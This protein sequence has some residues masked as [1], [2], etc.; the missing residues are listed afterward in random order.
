MN[1]HWWCR[2]PDTPVRCLYIH[3]GINLPCQKGEAPSKNTRWIFF[4]QVSLLPV[5][6]AGKRH[7]DS[8]LKL[9][10]FL[11]TK[12]HPFLQTF[13]PQR[14]LSGTVK[15]QPA[16]NKSGGRFSRWSCWVLDLKSQW[17]NRL[18]RFGLNDSLYLFIYHMYYYFKKFIVIIQ[19]FNL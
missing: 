3:S 7:R 12:S 9:L 10:L 15:F 5:K 14:T 18:A 11:K 17:S 16:E 2:C 4:N 6:P 1:H 19:N 8:S 13:A